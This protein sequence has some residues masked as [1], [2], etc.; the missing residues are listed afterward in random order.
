MLQK[1]PQFSPK[2][3]VAEKR[4]LLYPYYAGFSEFF[5]HRVFDVLR[6]SRGDR[7]LDPWNGSGTTTLV[8][9]Q[10]GC[11]AA[12]VD[13]NPC[14]IVVAKARLG[15]AHDVQDAV[16]M[17]REVACIG[18]KTLPAGRLSLAE[19]GSKLSALFRLAS[20]KDVISVVDLTCAEA[21]LLTCLFS[22]IRAHAGAARSK[23]PTWFK[24]GAEIVVQPDD[25]VRTIDAALYRAANV[26]KGQ[27]F[28]LNA[29]PRFFRENF[30]HPVGCIGSKYDFVITSPPYLTR[31][32]YVMATLP[33]LMVLRDLLDLD[34]AE[35]RRNMLGAPVVG[36]QGRD[37]DPRWGETAL[38]TLES[39]RSHSSKASGG[40]YFNFFCA[41]FAGL[42]DSMKQIA[43]VLRPG[44]TA[45][46]VVQASYYK[47][48]FVDL[49]RITAEIGYHFGL[50][51]DSRSDFL[52]GRS[53]STINRRA[54]QYNPNKIV[55][56]EAI[57]YMRKNGYESA[58]SADGS[59]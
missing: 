43:R 40:Y 8:A 38:R 6:I 56:S 21:I 44:G 47:E 24:A 11:E 30:R 15:S 57:V 26:I 5:V 3:N 29:S 54:G 22:A 53:M 46:L 10:R 33:E 27:L 36:S 34:I 18:L 55:D 2:L 28:K 49:P 59:R 58:G 37:P 1:R 52:V 45:A 50:E 41:Y 51:F 20:K 42:S 23:N 16:S 31:I 4:N 12:G 35:L 19:L 32:D 9:A 48:V 39:I 7:I 14:L 25:L 13:L 17:W